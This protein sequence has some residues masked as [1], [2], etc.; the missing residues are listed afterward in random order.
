MNTNYYENGSY[1]ITNNSMADYK[2]RRKKDEKD[3]KIVAEYLDNYF[4]PTFTTTIT[5]NTEKETQIQGLDVSVTDSEGYTYTIDEKAAT[6]WIGKSLQTFAHEISSVNVAGNTYK[7][8]FVNFKQINKY[9]VYIWID[10]VNNVENTLTNS[11]DISKATVV[12]CNKKNLYNYMRKKHIT[13]TEL[14]EIGE[15]LRQN[16]IY[17]TTKNG[18]KITMQVKNQ[19]KAANILIPRDTLINTLSD[20]AVEITG[21]DADKEVTVLHKQL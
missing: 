10:E 5:R 1:A 20:Y 9:Y 13:S 19:E 3:E 11:K 17:S 6:R 4:Y 16:D 12:L 15:Y 2:V 21:K 14:L 7:G 18:L 8:W